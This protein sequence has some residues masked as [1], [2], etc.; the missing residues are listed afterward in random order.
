M[1]G[2]WCCVIKIGKPLSLSPDTAL[3]FYVMYRS[4]CFWQLM[5]IKL[6]TEQI[7]WT[8]KRGERTTEIL[9]SQCWVKPLANSAELVLNISMSLFKSSHYKQAKNGPGSL[10][11]DTMQTNSLGRD[12]DKSGDAAVIC[13][14]SLRDLLIVVQRAARC[15]SRFNFKSS[16]K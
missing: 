12:K 6:H 11:V 10:F 1:Q 13:S 4:A 9:I 15:S 5:L 14:M 8:R 2:P 3:S 16:F 7:M